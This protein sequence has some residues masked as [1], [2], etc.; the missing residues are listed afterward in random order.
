MG[1][2]GALVASGDLATSILNSG[3]LSGASAAAQTIPVTSF[4]IAAWVYWTAGTANEG[5]IF[6][7]GYTTGTGYNLSVGSGAGGPGNYLGLGFPGQSWDIFGSTYSL[8]THEWVFVAVTHAGSNYSLYAN[9][10]LIYSITSGAQPN[11]P[12]SGIAVI[13]TTFPGYLQE[14][15]HYSYALSATQ[16]QN[17]YLAGTTTHGVPYPGNAILADNP[18]A[19]WRFGEKSGQ[20]AYDESGNA[21]HGTYNGGVTLNQTGA[22]AASGDSDGA[23]LLNG[24]SGYVSVPT[25]ASLA[26]TSGAFE[27]WLKTS[28]AG[29][30]YDLINKGGSNYQININ[31]GILEYCVYGI[32]CPGAASIAVNDGNYHHVV[33]NVISNLGVFY[34]DGVKHSSS[35]TAVPITPNSSPLNIGTVNPGGGQFPG[36]I[37]EVAFYNYPLSP[38]QI[39]NHYNAG[40]GAGWWF[41]QSRSQ[42]AS[43]WNLLTGIYDGTTAQL[44]MNGQQECSV[45]TR[46]KQRI[47]ILNRSFTV[48]TPLFPE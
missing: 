20:V 6:Q 14:V 9:G 3:A 12:I 24:T 5:N 39:A 35:G 8:P 23:I 29:G 28:A 26:I 47:L 10:A 42:L 44:F 15:A 22:I 11:S 38:T 45:P 43:K 32:N 7:N 17:Y 48:L 25:S 40:K 41:C 19:Y 21:N 2:P 4:S 30:E 33:V 36:T 37:D 16:I 46:Y 34:V 18:V 27:L 31:G 1:Q 13:G